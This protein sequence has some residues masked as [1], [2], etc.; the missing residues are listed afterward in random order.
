MRPVRYFSG[1]PSPV[2]SPE[3]LNV[4]IFRENTEDVYAGIE[5]KQGSPEARKLI[6]FLE[7]E[8]GK[9][10]RKDSGIGVKP[11]SVTGSKG[12]YGAPYNTPLTKESKSVTLMHKG[13]IMKFT[14][15]ATPPLYSG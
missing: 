5:Y 6:A 12:L 2:K 15:G 8:F 4:V 7:S 11:M 10:V 1:V 3:K 9:K 13:N 14:E